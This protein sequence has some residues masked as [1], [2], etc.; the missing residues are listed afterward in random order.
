MRN[1][2]KLK[3]ILSK[4]SIDLSMDDDGCMQLTLV[5]KTDG[6]MQSFESSSYSTLI[7]KA[8]SNLLK[9]VKPAKAKK[10][11]LPPNA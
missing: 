4:Y 7:T 3:H 5:D 11:W 8:Y 10:V 1:T 6:S 2:T 9:Q